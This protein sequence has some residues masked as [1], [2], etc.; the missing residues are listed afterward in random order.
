MAKYTAQQQ[1]YLKQIGKNIRAFRKKKRISQEE[2]AFKANLDRSYIGSVER[3]ERNVAVLN[4]KKIA[5]ALRIKPKDI[6]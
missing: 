4:I 3:G 5:A 6:V 2:L 1:A